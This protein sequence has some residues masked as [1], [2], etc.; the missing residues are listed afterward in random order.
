MVTRTPLYGT[1][2]VQC[3]CCLWFNLRRCHY[4]IWQC[5]SSVTGWLGSSELET[6]WT[7]T[8]VGLSEVVYGHHLLGQ[9][10]TAENSV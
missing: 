5:I 10:H 8:F 6:T 7:E 1:L 9:R 3:L 4:A 2:Y